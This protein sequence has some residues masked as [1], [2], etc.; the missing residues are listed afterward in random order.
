MAQLNDLLVMGKTSFIGE[1]NAFN[2]FTVIAE[3]DTNAYITL[4]SDRYPQFVIKNTSCDRAARMDLAPNG[5]FTIHNR[6]G[7]DSLTSSTGQT[8]LIIR[9]TGTTYAVKDRLALNIVEDGINTTYLI[10]GQHNKPTAKEIGAYPSDNLLDGADITDFN[11]IG[12]GAWK[13][14]SNASNA[15]TTYAHVVFHKDWDI[16]FASQMAFCNNHSIWFRF[17]TSGAWGNWTSYFLPLSGG[18]IT[19]SIDKLGGSASWINGRDRALCRLTTYSAYSAIASMKTTN[20]SWEMGVYTGDKMYFTY[21]PDT[22]YSANNNTGYTQIRLEPSGVLY[23][24][25]WNDYAEYRNAELV[26]P[27]RVVIEH[28]SGEMKLSTERLQ[29]GA[30]VISDTFGFAIGE[31]E[32]CK[33]PIATTGRVLA[34]P[35]EDK[36]SYSLGAAVCSGPNGTVSLMTREEIREYPE[37]IIGTV[38]E[39]PKYEEWGTGKVK[40]NGRIWI[41]IK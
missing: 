29:P 41:R 18:T 32:E 30:E 8:S 6:S 36:D 13:I 1:T 11:N 25:A 35:N 5:V 3:Q 2:A 14:K 26:E 20:G 37:R 39:I 7:M 33:T 15:P 40:V 27:G 38:S 24:A 12:N 16:N 17:K 31:T 34:Y 19:G 21:C 9:P 23:G 4:L 22:N 10:Y 28:E